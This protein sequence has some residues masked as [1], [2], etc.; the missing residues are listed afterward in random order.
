MPIRVLIDTFL[1]TAP[2]GAQT[3]FAA[4]AGVSGPTV[5]RWRKGQIVP[6]ET[7]APVLADIMSIPEK[8]VLD[9]IT[10]GNIERQAERDREEVKR[11]Q[12]RLK[13][14]G[15]PEDEPR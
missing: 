11:L 13:Q 8:T 9:A 15:T 1:S 2:R 4:D 6:E 14:L 3:R 7:R 10:A 5:M 12:A